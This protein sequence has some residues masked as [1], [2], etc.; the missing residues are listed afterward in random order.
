MIEFGIRTYK[1]EINA[2]P[3]LPDHFAIIVGQNDIYASRSRIRMPMFDG[4]DATE[5]PDRLRGTTRLVYKRFKDTSP[6]PISV[7]DLILQ[8]MN[9]V[10]SLFPCSRRN[11]Q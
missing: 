11:D 10:L 2:M 3:C 5:V 6:K 9:H 1:A 4:Y 8:K 7:H